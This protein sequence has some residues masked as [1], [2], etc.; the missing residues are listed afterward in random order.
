MEDRSGA[1]RDRRLELL[2][3]STGPAA[4]LDQR[5]ANLTDRVIVPVPVRTL[6]DDLVAHVSRVRQTV[7][8]R[9]IFPGDERGRRDGDA[10]GAPT[11]DVAA[12]DANELRDPGAGLPLQLVQIDER[13][14]SVGH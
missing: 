9:R 2:T 4:N 5:D 12:L 14:P 3:L 13:P 11:A 10:G 1:R 7:D 8:L 6:N